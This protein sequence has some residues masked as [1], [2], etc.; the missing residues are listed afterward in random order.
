MPNV[1]MRDDAAKILWA[2]VAAVEPRAAVRRS[3]RLETDRLSAGDTTLDLA[4]VERVLIVGVG[5]AA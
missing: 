3:L 2:A 5:K 1:T 4:Q